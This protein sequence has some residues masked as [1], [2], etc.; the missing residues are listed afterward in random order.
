MRAVL[1]VGATVSVVLALS[2]VPAGAVTAGAETFSGFLIATGRTGDRQ[3]LATGLTATGVFNGHGRIVEVASLP[4]D[5][6]EVL[7]DDL[8]FAAGTMHLVSTNLDFTF[9]I[10]PKSCRGRIRAEQTGAIAGG[11]GRFAHATGSFTGSVDGT[12]LF[13]RL[14]DHS[15]DVSRPPIIERD[16]VASSGTLEF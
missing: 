1:G 7:R 9:D 2:A 16:D 15:C 14:A 11:T 6:D 3:V 12:A 10:D 13:A 8:V 4:G 5:P